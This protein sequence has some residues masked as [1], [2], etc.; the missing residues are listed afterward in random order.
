MDTTLKDDNFN[1][2]MSGTDT[3]SS[4][5]EEEKSEDVSGKYVIENFESFDDMELNESLLRG[6]YAYGFEKP[7]VIQ[8]KGIVPM[9][10]GFDLISQSQSGTG[11]TGTFSI[12]TLQ[13]IDTELNEA[14]ALI[15]A[16]TREL[17]LQIG[18]VMTTLANYMDIKVQSCIGG[19]RTRERYNSYNKI[20]AHIIVGT[21][22]RMYNYLKIGAINNK[23]L[24]LLVLD[25]ADK[26]LAHDFS[27]QICDIM[28]YLPKTAQIVLFSA[29]M[30]SEMLDITK[31]FMNNPLRILI[32]R[33]ELTL[34]GIKQF[35]ISINKD[36]QKFATICDL[37]KTIS[38]T[39]CIIYC[40]RSNRVE[41]LSNALIDNGFSVS[42][43]FGSMEQ[44]ERNKILDNFRSGSSRILITTDVLARGIDVQQV[45]LVINF[46]LPFEKETYIHRIGRSGRFGR[47]GVAIN[48]VTPH[49]VDTL[50]EL[51]EFYSTQI[52]ELPN[53]IA[54]IIN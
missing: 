27:D 19:I 9:T 48:M 14:Q 6:I 39:Q 32:P 29:T 24:K 49:D 53:N 23:H 50:K 38:V 10:K 16:P 4:T 3:G 20:K 35:Y 52:E 15:L 18:K 44:T 47:K 30:P 5:F 12:G 31:K 42:C 13:Q 43:L 45:S 2:L 51:R 33:D 41:Q 11:K 17:A 28:G 1:K 21:P 37:Y 54:D 26:L 40:N 22:G 46:D 34:D 8:Q 36:E 25:E 7:S